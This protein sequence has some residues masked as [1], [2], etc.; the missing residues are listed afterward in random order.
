MCSYIRKY[1]IKWDEEEVRTFRLHAFSAGLDA[2]GENGQADAD[3]LLN[4][5][6]ALLGGF[7]QRLQ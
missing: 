1:S 2:C 7:S 4:R 5:W 6:N 3:E